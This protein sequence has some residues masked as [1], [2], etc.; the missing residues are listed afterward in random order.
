MKVLQLLVLMLAGAALRLQPVLQPG[1][2]VELLL[3]L[4]QPLPR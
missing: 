3:L 2:L 1:L 4:P